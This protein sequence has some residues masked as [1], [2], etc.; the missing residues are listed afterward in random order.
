MLPLMAVLPQ[1]QSCG[2]FNSA[3]NV[4][5]QNIKALSIVSWNTL[6]L[7]AVDRKPRVARL[8]RVTELCRRNKVICLQ[9]THCDPSVIPFMKTGSLVLT[10]VG[11]LLRVLVV[12]VVSPLWFALKCLRKELWPWTRSSF[13]T[14]S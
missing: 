7:F 4:G 9:E 1:M 14:V 12:L 8:R 11:M 5:I 2:V 3:L 10:K 13:L 6:A